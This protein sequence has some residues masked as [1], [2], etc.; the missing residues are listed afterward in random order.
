[1]AV[2][3]FDT[4]D[5]LSDTICKLEVK[6]LFNSLK[7]PRVHKT[8]FFAHAVEVITV[9]ILKAKS[10]F[11]CGNSSSENYAGKTFCSVK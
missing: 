9:C 6:T 2:W 10:F 11:W 8:F 1:M 4:S 7:H 5:W 3:L